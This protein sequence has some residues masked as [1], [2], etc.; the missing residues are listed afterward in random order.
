MKKK[1]I[2]EQIYTCLPNSKMYESVHLHIN[3]GWD[4]TR[5][6]LTYFYFLTLVPKF[7]I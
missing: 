3:C 7:G 5:K 6:T 1:K 4:D 2:L